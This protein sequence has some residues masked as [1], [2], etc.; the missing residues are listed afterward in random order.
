ML[1]GGEAHAGDCAAAG[2]ALTCECSLPGH[3]ATRSPAN[4][5]PIPLLRHCCRSIQAIRCRSGSFED[6]RTPFLTPLSSSVSLDFIHA[7]HSLCLQPVTT[8]STCTKMTLGATATGGGPC[9]PSLPASKP[10]RSPALPP[11]TGCGTRCPAEHAASVAHW[12][13]HTLHCSA[14]CFRPSLAAVHAVQMLG[15]AAVGGLEVVPPDA[16]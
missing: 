14:R 2:P 8:Q 15:M 9:R 10:V 5:V 7:L 4:T 11:L 6:V 13:R 16:G 3:A 1:D 12:L